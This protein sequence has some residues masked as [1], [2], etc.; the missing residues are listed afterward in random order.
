LINAYTILY[1]INPV[2]FPYRLQA[3][4]NGGK[5]T[6]YKVCT[7]LHIR[8]DIMS[9]WL[10]KGTLPSFENLLLLTDYFNC[11]ADYLLG[12]SDFE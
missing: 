2:P 1:G 5:I 12:L 4:I 11:S 8:T 3:L 9:V 7:Q 6:P 10:N